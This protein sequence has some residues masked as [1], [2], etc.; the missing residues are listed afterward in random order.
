MQ[1][2][3]ALGYPVTPSKF[4]MLQWIPEPVL[5]ILARQALLHRV[6]DEIME[7]ALL[8]HARAGREEIGH[9]AEEFMVLARSTSVPTPAI[10]RLYPHLDPETPLMPEGSAE[11]PLKMG[12]MLAGMGALSLG[13]YLAVALVKRLCCGKRD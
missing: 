6:D 7:A 11:I 9:L 4:K 10:D 13:L 2:L 8:A 12:R 1:V 5:V 3:Q